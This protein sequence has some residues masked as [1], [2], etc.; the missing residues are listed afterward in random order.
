MSCGVV[1]LPNLRHNQIMNTELHELAKAVGEA[2][3][4]VVAKLVTAES[5]TGGYI[6]QVITSI[7]ESSNWFERGF[8]T[9][10]NEAKVDCLKVSEA[11]LSEL[12]AQYIFIVPFF[13]SNHRLLTHST[14]YFFSFTHF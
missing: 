12:H 3:L 10:S 7:P 2:L 6:S 1:L 14:Q 4:A 9:Y 5:C 13:S 11:I 8:V